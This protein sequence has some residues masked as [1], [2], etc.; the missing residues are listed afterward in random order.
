[1]NREDRKRI[2][3]LYDLIAAVPFPAS[4]SK[5]TTI[6]GLSS[7]A[8]DM[9]QFTPAIQNV[10]FGMMNLDCKNKE[11]IEDED[12][13]NPDEMLTAIEKWIDLRKNQQWQG[14][15]ADIIKFY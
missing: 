8:E 5:S 3:R 14:A 9:R 6:A 10:L 2:D 15:P 1:M 12:Y 11:L 13:N 4:G 7:Y